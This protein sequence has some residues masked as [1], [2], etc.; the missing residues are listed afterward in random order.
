MN[1]GISNNNYNNR[2]NFGMSVL[3]EESADRVIKN[4]TSKLSKKAYEKFWNKLDEV[5]ARQ[6]GREPNIIIKKAGKRNALA[7]EVVDNNADTAIKNYVTAQG[8]IHRN[9]SLKF[10]N[11]AEKKANRIGDANIRLERYTRPEEEHYY[12]GGVIPEETVTSGLGEGL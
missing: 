2:V 11:R 12:A 1:I 8:L 9:G 5:V 6:E 4:Q 3:L 7:A 10:L